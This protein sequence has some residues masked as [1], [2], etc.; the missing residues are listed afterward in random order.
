MKLKTSKVM[1][2]MLN[3]EIKKMGLDYNITQIRLT[4]QQFEYYV[5][6]DSY[7]NENDYNYITNKFNVIQIEYPLNYY[8]CNK[9]ITTNDLIKIYDKS[10][11]TFNGFL[12]EFKNYV[13]I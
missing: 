1:A 12:Q 6:I 9:Y 3:K 10:N 7:N 8:A 5:N 13:E 11:K 2:E 4:P